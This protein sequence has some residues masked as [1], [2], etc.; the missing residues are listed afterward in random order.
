MIRYKHV[1]GLGDRLT[2][3]HNME[4]NTLGLVQN[5]RPHT[6]S[7]DITYTA[8]GTV[9]GSL[10]EGTCDDSTELLMKYV[11]GEGRCAL[12]PVPSKNTLRLKCNK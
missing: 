2:T 12:V 11:Q 9:E 6:T 5:K 7:H 10:V 1:I 8:C 3:T 4:Q